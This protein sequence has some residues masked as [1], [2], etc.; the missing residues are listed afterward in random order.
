MNNLSNSESATGLLESPM[1]SEQVASHLFRQLINGELRGGQR[2][3]E[4]ELSRHFGISRN[5]IREAIRKL[6]E[7]GL[8]IS[9]PR[10]GTFVRSFSKKDVEDYFSFRIAIESFAVRQAIPKLT[11]AN[12]EELR[13]IINLMSA[14]A[15]AG[16][17]MEVVSTDVGFHQRICE[18]SGNGQTVRAFSNIQAEIQMSI[19][20][21]DRRYES[22]E[23]AVAQHWPVLEALASRVTERAVNEI[24][25][26]IQGSWNRIEAT[27]PDERV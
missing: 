6:E 25:A 20:C 14:A 8:L 10:R 23:E 21:I 16:R 2:I 19:S 22:M 9:S 5:P 13:S 12:I 11:D 1:L 18:L 3:N 7:R 4:A 17:E 27:Y 15:A 24:V 26:H